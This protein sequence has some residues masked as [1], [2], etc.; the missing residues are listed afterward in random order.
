M[1]YILIVLELNIFQKKLA[2]H[3]KQIYHNKYL[4]NTGIRF[5]NVWVFCIGFMLKG[6][7]LPDYMNL[8]SSNDYEKIDK[9]I[10]KYFQ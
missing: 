7:I 10:L 4:Q 8:I 3:K 2:I 1:Q 9:T 6:N 5:D